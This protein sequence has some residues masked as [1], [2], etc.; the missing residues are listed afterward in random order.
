MEH[1]DVLASTSCCQS[2]STKTHSFAVPF[3]SSQE[4]SKGLQDLRRSD[5]IPS[6]SVVVYSL[7]P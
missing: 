6:L 3:L 4:Y 1:D 2:R 5:P 7:E